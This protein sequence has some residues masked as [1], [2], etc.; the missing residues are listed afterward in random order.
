M[1]ITLPNLKTDTTRFFKN[2][3]KTKMLSR[4]MQSHN[5][6]INKLY[7]NRLTLKI[8]HTKQ[9]YKLNQ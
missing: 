3:S 8:E 5:I 6:Y 7:T 1:Y 4:K 9:N 2:K